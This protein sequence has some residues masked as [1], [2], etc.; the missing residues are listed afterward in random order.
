M[1]KIDL[2]DLLLAS[3]MPTLIGKLLVVYFG[4]NY[5]AFPG[6]GYGYGLAASIGFT[7]V[8]A[9]RFLWKYRNYKD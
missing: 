4:L 6:E 3:L 1:S 8:M 9:A 2:K 5:S 7:L